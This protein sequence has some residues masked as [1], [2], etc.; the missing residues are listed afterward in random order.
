[1]LSI[2]YRNKFWSL[3]SISNSNL[4][5]LRLQT[6][7]SGSQDSETSSEILRFLNTIHEN[8]LKTLYMMY[9]KLH[10]G[11]HEPSTNLMIFKLYLHFIQLKNIATAY[12][13]SWFANKMFK[14][15]SNFMDKVLKMIQLHENDFSHKLYYI[16]L[17][18]CSSNLTYTSKIL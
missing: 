9:H 3:N 6:E 2:A 14:I 7:S 18:T 5:L 4:N 16:T 13:F 8:L 10:I 17:C 15:S 12:G 1:M 11:Y